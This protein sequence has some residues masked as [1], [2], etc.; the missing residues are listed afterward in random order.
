MRDLVVDGSGPDLYFT[1]CWPSLRALND[2]VREKPIV[3]AGMANLRIKKTQY[4]V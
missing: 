1:G 3:F 2:V 4:E